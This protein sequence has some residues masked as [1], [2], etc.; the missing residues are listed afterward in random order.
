MACGQN[1]R[2][3]SAGPGIEITE[4]CCGGCVISATG[5]TNPP[6]PGTCT[7]LL[8]AD[9]SRPGIVVTPGQTPGFFSLGLDPLAVETPQGAQA[10]V[11]AA[12]APLEQCCTKNTGDIT[13]L[14]NRL[15][16]FPPVPASFVS[17]ADVQTLVDAAVKKALDE[18]KAACHTL[19][20][21]TGG[22]TPIAD[23]DRERNPDPNSQGSWED[24]GSVMHVIGGVHHVFIRVKRTGGL[25]LPTEN[26]TTTTGHS[27]DFVSDANPAQGYEGGPEAGNV[28]PDCDFL[29]LDEAWMPTSSYKV[30]AHSSFG[31][32]SVIL[33]QNKVFM[34]DWMVNNTVQTG[35]KIAFEY[36]FLKES[37]CEAA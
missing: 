9:A 22:V 27:L 1:C 12:K 14:V 2:R 26:E 32:G 3:L 34:L 8:V 5:G 33:F 17:P 10:K 19:Q 15:N 21:I 36:T 4:D 29:A 7:C 13:T 6:Q 11:D 37:P 35:H 30:S 24:D 16:A 25:Y 18:H 31:T 28:V 20:T 23:A